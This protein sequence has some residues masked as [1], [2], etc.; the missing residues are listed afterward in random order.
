MSQVERVCEDQDLEQTIMKGPRKNLVLFKNKGLIDVRA[1]TTFGIS[2]K[3]ENNANPIGY[4]GTGLKYALAV[5]AREEIPITIQSGREVFNFGVRDEIVRGKAFKIVTMNGESLGFTTDLGKT[6]QL[7][8]AFRELYSNCIDEFGVIDSEICAPEPDENYT[9]IF[10]EDERFVELYENRG[11]IFLQGRPL[12]ETKTANIHGGASNNVFYRGIKIGTYKTPFMYR[13]NMTKHVDLTEDRTVKFDFQIR[14]TIVDAVLSSQ[15]EK[16]I[17]SILTA[18]ENTF[19]STLNFEDHREIMSQP[20]R[21]V[22][23]ELHRKKPEKTN[24]SALH[25]FDRSLK[26]QDRFEGYNPTAEELDACTKAIDFLA[27]LN[28]PVDDYQIINVVTMGETTLARVEDGKIYLS[29]RLY[30]MGVKQLASTL[31]EEW[32]HLKHGYDDLTRTMQTYLFDTIIGLGEQITG[33][34]L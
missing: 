27:R 11:E 33:E 23:A 29:S 4:F 24:K 28:I 25:L 8:Q 31:F 32:V 16:F 2:A 20:F 12:I 3:D 10:V 5:L 9:Q 7:W 14:D 21:N 30:K 17:E 26:I 18:P 22:A 1:I 13:Y 19:E 15:D 6:W 34:V